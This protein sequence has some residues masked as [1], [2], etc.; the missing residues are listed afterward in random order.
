MPYATGGD[1]QTWMMS[2]SVPLYPPFLREQT[3]L[4]SFIYSSILALISAL[5]YVHADRDGMW[6]GHYDIKPANILLFSEEDKWVWK[7]SDFG[8]SDLKSVGTEPG[9]D[10]HIGTLDYEPPEY[11]TAS[12]REE[13]LSYDVYAMGCVII[14]FAA[15]IVYPDWEENQVRAFHH[16]RVEAGGDP[17]Q[18]KNHPFCTKK[19]VVDRWVGRLRRVHGSRNLERLLDTAEA[20]MK[21]DPKQRLLAFDAAIDIWSQRSQGE[22][23]V[24]FQ[25]QCERL[26]EGQGPR[27]E[28]RN[29]YNPHERE[30]AFAALYGND[31]A[32]IREEYL[33]AIGWRKPPTNRLNHS[34]TEAGGTCIVDAA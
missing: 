8:H 2:E 23:L 18:S 21:E 14:Q 9:T 29:S 19:P 24:Y 12:K 17:S 28:F 32:K 27:P 13:A 5:A 30:E 4:T 34:S 25:T 26:T 10:R 22:T 20:M 11:W 7:L 15:F 1:L 6:T 31:R 33:T 3:S 16:Q